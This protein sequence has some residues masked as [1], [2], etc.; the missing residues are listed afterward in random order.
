MLIPTKA[1][2][3]APYPEQPLLRPGAAAG[4]R[5]LYRSTDTPRSLA[6]TAILFVV[7][8]GLVLFMAI[9]HVVWR[10]E[11]RALTKALD[12]DNVFAMIT[13]LRSEG[14]PSLWYLLLR[15][16]HDIIPTPEVVPIVALIVAAA[17]VLLLLL[18]SPFSTP[19]LALLLLTHFAVFEYAVMARNYGIS[20]LLLFL[21]ATFYQNHRTRGVLLG[22]L[23]FLLANTNVHSVLLVGAFLLFWLIDLATDQTIARPHALKLFIINAVI[24][25]L[26]VVACALTVYPPIQDAAMATGPAALTARHLLEDIFSP[27]SQFGN[28]VLP[29]AAMDRLSAWGMPDVP[30]L[31]TVILVGSTLGLLRRPAALLASLAALVVFSLFFSLV[32]PG[33]YRH[34][35][36]WL[37][38]LVSMYW[39][40]GG[41][42]TAQQ[43]AT[44]RGVRTLSTGGVMLFLALMMLQIPYGGRELARAAGFAPPLGRSRDF[45]ALVAKHP[46][47]HDA[48]I[49]ADPDYLVEPL[50]YYMPN[51]AYLLRQQQFGHVALFIKH[52]RLTLSLDDILASA[53]SVHAQTGK[54]IIILLEDRLKPSRP[55]QTIPESYDWDLTTTP[56]QV[57]TFLADTRLIASLGPAKTDETYDVY[58]LNPNP[59]TS[60]YDP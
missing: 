5:W 1:A 22:A 13:G 35:A 38:F 45:A 42:G 57:K 29:L 2:D 20:M 27:A 49:M 50:P 33:T 19:V 39:I 51:Q 46:E 6:V 14:H 40:A 24:A 8:F 58:V 11:V 4:L 44:P 16:A 9:N 47:L 12:G 17:A 34:Y 15:G 36:L 52:A 53:R 54:P 31:M 25:M 23:L 48:I 59:G 26:G 7:W 3:V 55:A 30:L 37:V 28:I 41:K 56:E 32:Y 60:N 10:D 21:L 18:K 43:S